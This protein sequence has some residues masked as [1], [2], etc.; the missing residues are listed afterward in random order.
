MGGRIGQTWNHWYPSGRLTTMSPRSTPS[1]SPRRGRLRWFRRAVI[2]LLVAANVV[3]VALFW[4]LRTAES[5]L[6]ETA[7]QVEEVVP[8]LSPPPEKKQDPITFLVIGS[9]SRAGLDDLEGFGNFAGS[10]ADVI[11]LVQ[12]LPDTGKVQILSLPR[13]LYVDIEGNGRNRI[14]AAYAFGGAPL[15]VKTVKETTGLAVHHY[16]EVDFVGFESI[17][18]EL[19]GV[20]LDFPFPARD[21]KSGLDVAA[22]HQILNGSQALA[23][24]RSRHYQELRDG[25]WVSVDASDIGRTRRQQQLVFAILSALKRPSTVTDVGDL[26]RSFAQHL[27]VDSTLA[28]RGFLD[29][30]FSL[31]GLSA[32]D[33][34][35]TT[36][37]TLGRTIDGRSVLVPDE[38]AA[39]AVIEAF[40]NGESL[41]AA[42]EGPLQVVV[43]N[44]NGVAGAAAHW[45]DVLEAAGYQ[46]T[47]IGDADTSDF[48]ETL[49]VVRPGEQSRG[50]SIVDALGFGTVTTGTVETSIDAMV[51]VGAD[52]AREASAEASTG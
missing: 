10:R 17:V 26:V 21:L 8:E 39:S 15:M 36:L 44:G 20:A 45:R 4:T 34:E 48:D 29:L 47:R 50:V 5:A 11:M 31:R 51:I 24:A 6:R 41:V 23:Y 27:S 38:P 33:I 9:D 13:D 43:L 37:P 12:V 3:A 16:V 40:R 14:N 32:A 19:G 42:A 30:A 28:D 1:R 2:V 52:A 46:V 35:A 7:V 49:V 22:G 18:D 25:G